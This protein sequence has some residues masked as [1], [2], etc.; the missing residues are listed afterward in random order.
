MVP[1]SVK[2]LL[3]F[4]TLISPTISISPRGNSGCSAGWAPSGLCWRYCQADHGQWCYTGLNCNTDN[5]C[6]Q[7]S[8]CANIT[9]QDTQ[10]DC[11]TDC[12]FDEYSPRGNDG[13][14]SWGCWR[15]CMGDSGD[16][17][18]TGRE[19]SR[20]N[21]GICSEEKSC[22]KMNCPA[23]K[24][25]CVL[26]C[27]LKMSQPS[28]SG[29]QEAALS[30]L[31]IPQNSQCKFVLTITPALRQLAENWIT[32]QQ[33]RSNIAT[34]I[35]RTK[36]YQENKSPISRNFT[37]FSNQCTFV[38][39]FDNN[40]DYSPSDVHD[41]LL[42]HY[43]WSA[44]AIV[45]LVTDL[46]PPQY[47]PWIWVTLV[48]PVYV[49]IWDWVTL[50]YTKTTNRY[51]QVSDI[52][53]NKDPVTKD[54][55]LLEISYPWRGGSTLGIPCSP[56]GT[57]SGKNIATY[58]K[59]CT[60]EQLEYLFLESFFNLSLTSW[61]GN[62]PDRRGDF[63]PK[64]VPRRRFTE[65]YMPDDIAALAPA[66][67]S[68]P[69][70]IYC[71]RHGIFG[72]ANAS[73]DVW[74]SPFD[75]IMWIFVFVMFPLL[76]LNSLSVNIIT[77]PRNIVM[78]YT[79]QIYVLTSILIR[80]GVRPYTWRLFLFGLISQ[81]IPCLY[82]SIITGKLLAPIAPRKFQDVGELVRTGYTIEYDVTSYDSDDI[83]K[84]IGIEFKKTRVFHRLNHTFHYN[85]TS[86]LL[87]YYGSD[88]GRNSFLAMLGDENRLRSYFSAMQELELVLLSEEMEIFVR[89]IKH[90]HH[91]HVLQVG[92]R[93]SFYWFFYVPHR[94]MLIRVNELLGESGILQMWEEMWY[95]YKKL[96]QGEK[97]RKSE[98]YKRDSPDV[99]G[100][101]NLSTFF[102]IWGIFVGF[103]LVL[104]IFEFY[105]VPLQ[106]VRDI[107]KAGR[108]LVRIYKNE[109]FQTML[110]STYLK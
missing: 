89:R 62:E 77:S 6:S 21:D 75:N 11:V 94:E 30:S 65:K 58:N 32:K 73:I 38:F 95:N 27:N 15:Y 56:M 53:G 59:F 29:R 98:V 4:S 102:T 96:S 110:L 108:L 40:F 23:G 81:L 37:K 64:I 106:F 80:N 31:E 104:F 57:L 49:H 82:E 28:K 46:S 99:I 105:K 69:G 107:Y 16:W 8:I 25:G 61:G 90:R 52:W 20:E 1:A 85:A 7:R 79:Y 101:E 71:R 67:E 3:L 109:G 10:T 60:K 55:S 44:R 14:S 54:F 97:Q 84:D 72:T 36:T 9:C 50:E 86:L 63:F 22:R 93:L 74:L 45:V 26:T 83:E 19:C 88:Y 103:G 2:F 18:Y 51:H 66:S 91:C 76:A 13:C 39:I 35:Y 42:V 33:S 47:N 100:L 12:F 92:D 41:L 5:Q 34:W 43:S 17:C 87:E 48:T 78:N 68:R 70:I 24:K